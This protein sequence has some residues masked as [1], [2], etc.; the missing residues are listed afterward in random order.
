MTSGPISETRT[1]SSVTRALVLLYGGLVY[2]SFLATFLYAVAFVGG[3][4]VP[5]T[6]DSGVEGP[7]LTAL[8]IDAALLGVF[9]VQHNVMARRW[10]KTRI[11]AVI[12]V[13]A[14]RS[15]FVLATNLALIAMFVFWRPIPATV[16]HVENEIVAGVLY[17]LFAAG[18][19]IVLLSTF[20]I[21]HFSLFGLAQVFRYGR[22]TKYEPPRFIVRS[23]YRYVRHP[24]YFGFFLGMTA[25]PYMTAGH[26]V[27]AVG[28][29]AFMLWSIPLEER[30][31]VRAHGDDYRDYQQRVPRMFPIPGRSW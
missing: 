14:E 4:W 9:A 22:G 26:L 21:D 13:A 28:T 7:M 30:D 29:L 18:W 24:L 10:F 17:A 5:T 23:L 3:F 6:L 27:F 25:T 12:P 19:L 8:L 16:W 31:L 15:T 1:S 2:V 11:T 20:L